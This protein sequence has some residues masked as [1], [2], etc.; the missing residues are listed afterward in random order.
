MAEG[1]MNGAPAMTPVRGA[2]EYQ[3]I[4]LRLGGTWLLRDC[5]FSLPAGGFLGVVGPTGSG[6]SL[7]LA[8]LARL[9]DPTEGRILLDGRELRDWPLA[10][11]RR[12][13]GF[14][15]QETL[16]FS[17]SLR[18]NVALGVA[19]PTAERLEQAVALARLEQD[20]PQLPDGL[21]T[22]VGERGVTLSGGQKQ[23]TA[24]A[25]ALL[26]DPRI[27]VLDDALSA[28]D[29]ATEAAMLRGLHGFMAQRTSIVATHRLSVVRNADLI[30]VLDGGRI[31][32]RGRH[33]ELAAR[34][35]LYARLLR[36]QQLEELLVEEEVQLDRERENGHRTAI[37]RSA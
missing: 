19:D 8:L 7:L 28:V 27:L 26:K 14:V 35:G 6:K 13:V 36:R 12:A 1:P 16:L 18:D 32:E 37:R 30:L 24:I 20:L 11:L 31:V 33:D 21:D 9:Y 15:P 2:I 23:R 4:G 34:G 22:V 29:A 10:T 17:K 3:G 5:S 25:R